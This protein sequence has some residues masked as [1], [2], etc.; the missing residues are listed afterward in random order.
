MNNI[1][2][3][4]IL[5]RFDTSCKTTFLHIQTHIP[6]LFPDIPIKINLNKK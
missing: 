5:N 3:Y 4:R 1:G 2:D 6:I